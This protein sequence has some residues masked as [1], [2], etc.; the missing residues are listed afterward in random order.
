MSEKIIMSEKNIIFICCIAEPWVKV[1]ESLKPHGLNAS[2]VVHW[3]DEKETYVNSTLNAC[4]FQTVEDA[5]AG[6]GFPANSI[7]VV[8]DEEQLK[9]I[10]WYESQ[11]IT[12]MNRLDPTESR[13]TTGVRQYYFRDLV[14]HWLSVINDKNIELVV[15]PS[16]PHRVFDY[17]LYVACKIKS[18]D[19]LSF[20]LT[21]FGSNSIAIYDIDKMPEII[22][23][24]E[25]ELKVPTEHVSNRVNKILGD[26]KAA[27]PDYMKA[28]A[29][30]NKSFLKPVI[31]RFSSLIRNFIEGNFYKF[32]HPNT[33]WTQFGYMPYE[34]K[35]GWWE[36]SY[37]KISHAL[38][39][40]KLE[41][42]YE[43]IVDCSWDKSKPY[44]FVALHYQPEETT[45]PTGGSYADQILMIQLLNEVLPSN[46]NIIIKEH[47]SQFYRDQEGSAGRNLLFYKRV[48]TIS[49]RI[50]FDSVDSDPFSIIDNAIATVTVSGTIGW[51]SAIRGTPTINFGRAWY[52]GMPR[53]FRVKNKVD[54]KKV[55]PQLADLKR[56]DLHNE[57]LHFH[58][59]LE[60]SFI[61]AT[62]YKSFIGKN[63]VSMNESI[64]N[65]KETV[66]SHSKVKLTK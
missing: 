20:Q 23:D 32:K 34:S 13:M 38:K 47:K 15:S 39:V 50:F 26:Y 33:Y 63:D 16:I 18:I 51:E 53:A 4:H 60:D 30:N 59:L 21:P 41:V 9:S 56:K 7:P 10:A 29:K 42:A 58:K 66:L 40:K 3:M 52:E 49:P 43:K 6:K 14:G 27:I 5:W 1:M 64:Q 36:Y 57:I 2:Y 54:L 28:H 19:Y 46:I 65:L 44:I 31:K 25:G 37:I 61:K 12:M 35:M 48:S 22:T 8:L 55:L 24:Y 45:C 62:H 17:A 11:A